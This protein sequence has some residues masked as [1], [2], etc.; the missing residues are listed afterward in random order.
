M[1][2][3][4][5]QPRRNDL[6]PRAWDREPYPAGRSPKRQLKI[7]VH[8]TPD[9]DLAMLYGIQKA[10]AQGEIAKGDPNCAVVF[11]LDTTGLSAKHDIDALHAVEWDAPGVVEVLKDKTVRKAVQSGDGL[12]AAEAIRDAV[13]MWESQSE[14]SRSW[15]ATVWADI[16][17][18]TGRRLLATLAEDVDEANLL[19][20][21]RDFYKHG[22][23]PLSLWAEAVQQFRYLVPIGIT[24]V[25][26]IT[27]VRPVEDEMLNPN[28]LE[29]T[30]DDPAQPQRMFDEDVW[31]G[32]YTPDLVELWANPHP[33]RVQRDLERGWQRR[34]EFHGTDLVRAR[35]AFPALREVLV[36][37]W[38]Y[39]QP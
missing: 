31:A 5:R 22:E 29:D 28:E 39:T 37:P 10:S 11:R 21:L 19:G 27:A 18:D 8:T 23:L 13:E 25:L 9:F 34:E 1:S 33:R 14:A 30:D 38:A 36:S 4:P 12:A 32:S 35:Q 6:D 20:V 15:Q 7:G 24:R 2:R 17:G 16:A 26:T 3:L